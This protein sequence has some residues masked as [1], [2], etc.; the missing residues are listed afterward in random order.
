MI[1]QLRNNNKCTCTS[2]AYRDPRVVF[3]KLRSR[4]QNSDESTVFWEYV[5]P[6]GNS[7]HSSRAMPKCCRFEQLDECLS[8][9]AAHGAVQHEVDGVVHQSGDV[10]DVTERKIQR[11][12]VDRL[13]TTD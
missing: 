12:E 7:R 1:K 9:L 5:L 11:R 13:Q 2:I 3:S 10:H 6:L 4:T 8:E